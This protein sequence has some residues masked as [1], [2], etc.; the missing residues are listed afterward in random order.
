[1]RLVDTSGREAA[2]EMRLSLLVHIICVCLRVRGKLTIEI[3][4]VRQFIHSVSFIV[5]LSSEGGFKVSQINSLSSYW[6]TWG[7]V[8]ESYSGT[9]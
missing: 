2:D 3:H 8:N 9:V 1:M 6:G 5:S 4:S 7:A